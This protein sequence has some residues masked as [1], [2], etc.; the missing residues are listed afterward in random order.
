M[1]GLKLIVVPLGIPDAVK[2]TE[3]LKLP[4]I[5][6]LMVALPCVPCTTLNDDGEAET[7]RPGDEVVTVNVTVVV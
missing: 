4:L 3:L 2:A 5:V 6:V 1:L 7:V